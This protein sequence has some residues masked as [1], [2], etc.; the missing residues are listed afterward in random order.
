MKNLIHA[1]RALTL[2][3]LVACNG[4]GGAG[5][6]AGA[7]NAAG[8]SAFVPE[9]D[10]YRLVVYGDPG[11]TFASTASYNF[12]D[13]VAVNPELYTIDWALNLPDQDLY[14]SEHNASR[15][16]LTFKKLNAIPL[17]L[18][19]YWNDNLVYQRVFSVAGEQV[20][21]LHNL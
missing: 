17:T 3:I 19:I 4:G 21:I 8:P 5:A 12:I 20:N 13:G 2:S 11:S 14:E 7:G 18:E 6:K 16:L 1:L 10:H 15:L 9:A